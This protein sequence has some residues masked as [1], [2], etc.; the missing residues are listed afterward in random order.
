MLTLEPDVPKISPPPAPVIAA[1]SHA[2]G[3]GGA[4]P[5]SV[6]QTTALGVAIRRFSGNQT[7]QALKSSQNTL[8]AL[9]SLRDLTLQAQK[10]L[11]GPTASASSLNTIVKQMHDILGGMDASQTPSWA[12]T[13]EDA[14][15]NMETA[16][17]GLGSDLSGVTAPLPALSAKPSAASAASG[18]PEGL[19]AAMQS[20]V[21]ARSVID[22]SADSVYQTFLDSD[23]ANAV[24]SPGDSLIAKI[25]LSSGSL[26]FNLQQALLQVSGNTLL[27]RSA[28]STLVNYL[29]Q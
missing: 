21:N 23:A 2:A 28:I 24:S 1:G 20:V 15:T 14:L 19:S 11:S 27:D 16:L 9:Q 22:A 8:S 12:G 5:S 10:L 26:D 17:G 18:S 13:L 25:D 29:L 3:T 4:T 6:S 7:I